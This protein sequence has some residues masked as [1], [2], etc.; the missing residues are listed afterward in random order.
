[1]MN[2]NFSDGANLILRCGLAKGWQRR[3]GDTK[4]YR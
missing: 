1:L 2:F 3:Q 4:H